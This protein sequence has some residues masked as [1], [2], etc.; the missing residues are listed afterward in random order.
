MNLIPRFYF[1]QPLD[2]NRV[3]GGPDLE[4]NALV[5]CWLG[6]EVQIKVPRTPKPTPA[7][8]YD[9]PV[10]GYCPECGQGGHGDLSGRVY[11]LGGRA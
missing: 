2:Q 3:H 6:C 10:G 8:H 1:E 4:F 11:P 7:A 5:I 9:I